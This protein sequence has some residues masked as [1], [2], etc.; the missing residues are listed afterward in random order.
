MY[1]KNKKISSYQ[2][3]ILLASVVPIVVFG[4]LTYYNSK[5]ER[6]Q[7]TFEH[8]ES[9]NLH[10]K[11][12]VLEYFEN[13][14]F[15]THA[16]T[17][18][19]S[20]LQE[21]ATRNIVNIQNLQKD[22]IINY[23]E[24]VEND[25]VSLAKKDVF[26][27]IYSFLNRSKKVDQVYID[28]I[29]TYK[30]E[31]GISSL[32]MMDVDG[33]IVYSSDDPGLLGSNA[34]DLTEAFEKTCSILKKSEIRKIEASF[35]TTSYNAKL[36]K[37]KQY[38]V[39]P[40]K[41]VDGYIAIEINL[42][43]IH[44]IIQ[45]VSSLGDTAETYLV[46]RHKGKTYLAS[47]REKKSGK[48]GDEKN[49]IYVEKGFT[50]S[51]TDIKHGSLG[52]IE[53]VGYMPVKIK[54]MT[55]SM[56]TTVAY[57]EII[58]PTINGSDYFEQF[59]KDYEYSNIML[60]GPQGE[61]FYSITKGD[62]YKTNILT[63]KYASSDLAVAVTKVFEDKEFRLTDI[64][65]YKASDEEVSQFA[66]LPI[67]RKDGSIQSIVVI[68]I[69]LYTLNAI[70]Q[71]NKG[72]YDTYETYL[73][74]EDKKLR[75]DTYLSPLIHTVENAFKNNILLET[76]AVKHASSVSQQEIFQD[77]R[78]IRVLSSFINIEYDDFKWTIVSEVDE[79]EVELMLRGLKTNIL[80]FVFISSLVA[81]I[82]MFIIT[83]QKKKQDKKVQHTA[84]HDAL[85]GL[86]NR[87]FALE[88]L[89]FMVANVKRK[90][91]KGAVLFL[92][93]DKFKII[94]D[95]Y[96]HKAGDRVLV[97]IARR[98]KDLLR[99]EDLIARLG[100][101][102]FILVLNQ[103]ETLNGIDTLCNKIIDTI[104]QPIEDG[105]KSYKVGISIGIA[106][107]PNDS[108]NA[109]ELL[110]FADTAMFNTKDNG[111]NGFTY[112]S[113]E[114]TEKSLQIARVESELTDAISSN[115]LVLH[116]QPQVNIQNSKVIGVE[117]L[118][119]WNH[120]KDGLVM[121]NDFIPI[122]EEST[123]I[124]DLG[125][126][127]TYEAC[128]TFK[129]WKDNGSDLEYIAVNMST[130]QLQ[131]PSCIKNIQTI[132]DVLDFDPEWL[133]IE[134]TE[135]TLIA[136]LESTISNIEV[137]KEMGIKFSIDD[138]GTGYSSLSYLKSLQISTL[139]IDREFIKDMLED[140]D[141]RTI[142]QAIILM[143]HTLGYTIVAEGAE[144]KA[145]VEL[146]KTF[147]CDIVQGYYYAKPLAEKEL[148]KYIDGHNNA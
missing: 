70:L 38:A 130:K 8:I 127:V 49:G 138:F 33:N 107:F 102:E 21:Q 79:K 80:L 84:T 120:P 47:D 40:F 118:V 124:L 4:F 93:L 46:Y 140:K 116:Y 64:V 66:L 32:L 126:W 77:Y 88:Y 101:D 65:S 148:L 22:N 44:K 17:K 23:Y 75:S 43:E 63:G 90:K 137:F 45:N 53:L 27:Y 73:I 74:G 117:A 29:F 129:N 15:N 58:S 28:E 144:T 100:G 141:D 122:A 71:A 147:D 135:T 39:A 113:K 72:I 143:G 42:E 68:E 62:D 131:C 55:L 125:Y 41:D 50:E 103:Y 99:D 12:N 16:L 108:L 11:A 67:V 52:A 145:E 119:R 89:A 30:E 31:L 86:P 94:N 104:S 109:V 51:G 96:G 115:Q 95:S 1:L 13:V 20:F 69:N 76:Y 19:V 59:I 14:K 121:P 34:N 91:N 78:G 60:I 133:E 61:I 110:Q 85:T 82:V 35:V 56:Q 3:I 83:N 123:L 24:G 98:L 7:S 2:N 142:V 112:Y 26:Q 111:R 146:L 97:E 87:K 106:T 136:N 6:M 105:D 81:L 25:I 134:I 9:L 139:K 54:N 36:G 5:Q 10:N 132:L 37:Y 128:K 92:D 114:M 48:I 18:T 57:T